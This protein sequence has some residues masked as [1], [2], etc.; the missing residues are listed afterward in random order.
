MRCIPLRLLP[1]T[2]TWRAP[3]TGRTGGY[4]DERHEVS[5]VRL[6]RSRQSVVRDWSVADGV[7]GT[8]YVDATNSVGEVPPVGALVSVD[9]ADE[10]V[11]RSVSPCYGMGGR[12]H[13]TELV[14]G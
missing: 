13:H 11:V 9:G 5:H 1:S 3:S 2:M 6:D 12:L 7:T 8:V 10:M 14:V 4:S